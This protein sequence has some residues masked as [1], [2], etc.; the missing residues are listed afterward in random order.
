MLVCN[1]G[2]TTYLYLT[3][4]LPEPYGNKGTH[5]V[6]GPFIRCNYCEGAALMN[7]EHRIYRALVF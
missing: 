4:Y 3:W 5:A 1:G 6:M 7:Y 2:D